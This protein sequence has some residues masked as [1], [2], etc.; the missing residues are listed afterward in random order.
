M[1]L[2]EID[3]MKQYYLDGMHPHDQINPLDDISCCDEIHQEN[4][5]IFSWHLFIGLMKLIIWM[6]IIKRKK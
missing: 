5:L 2:G 6:K 4:G 1:N 3:L